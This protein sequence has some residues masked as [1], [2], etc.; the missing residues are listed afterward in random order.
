MKLDN[1]TIR[2]RMI[3]GFALIVALMV[4]LAWYAVASMQEE[5]QDFNKLLE[6]S[7]GATDMVELEAGVRANGRRLFE[8][9]AVEKDKQGQIKDRI[10]A[11]KKTVDDALKELYLHAETEAEKAALKKAEELRDAFVAELKKVID[12]VDAG[13]REKAVQIALSA[14]SPA[15][16]KLN[17]HTKELVEGAEKKLKQRKEQLDAAYK[18][19]LRTIWMVVLAI[20]GFATACAF[21]ITRSITGPIDRAV[22]AAESVA[23][24]DFA[25]SLDTS[26]RDEI[27]SLM[28]A[29]QTMITSIQNFRAEQKKMAEK[30]EQGWIDEKIPADNFAGEFAAMAH[31]INDLVQAHIN[32][33]MS[34]VEHVTA[35]ANCDFSKPM[36]DLP[37]K[38]AMISKAVNEVRSQLQWSADAAV[39]NS[40]IRQAL[41]NC[42]TNVMIANKDGEIVY[43]NAAVHSM[44]SI[45]QNDIRSQL[46]GFDV[47]KVI[48]SSF[49]QFHKNPSHQRNLLGSLR[50]THRAQIKVGPRI[51]SL[52]A[53]PITSAQGERI[54]TVVEWGDRTAEVLAETELADLVTAAAAGDFSQRVDEN[55]KSGFVG[56]MARAMNQLLQVSEEGLND[57]ARVLSALAAG[58]LSQRIHGDYHGTFGALKDDA[59][60]TSERLSEVMYEV[61]QAADALSGAAG[62]ISATAQ[63]LSQAAS[64]QAS[65]VERTS[66][67]VEQMSA[68]VAQNSENAKITDGMASQSSQEAVQGG[69]AVQKTADAMKQIAAKIGIVDDIA[70]Q[71]NLLA[72]NAA[73]EAARAGEHGKG[74][75]V[76]AAEVRKLAERSQVAAKEIGE[77]AASSVTVSD[78]AGNLLQ[79]MIPSIR[80]T[81]DL[82]QEISAASEEQSLGLGQIS[83][84]MSQLNQVTQQ[85][86]SASEELAATAEEMSGQAE[87]LQDLVGFFQIDGSAKRQEERALPPPAASKPKRA[88]AA[89][90]PAALPDE[91]M[92]RRF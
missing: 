68:S 8:L 73:I 72:L 9:L 82:V 3:G 67:S 35:Y 78:Q 10:A 6:I 66:A 56:V 42:S 17:T 55:G 69:E 2:Q 19:S 84:A 40:R 71:T 28:R 13:E 60:L 79:A 70:Y 20:A 51:F 61:R 89:P 46:P 18:S 25:I 41:D 36:Q 27:G 88:S 43:M 23:A 85:N 4:G 37:G 31:S 33:K 34:V 26:A 62:Q 7:D 39:T 75:A 77:L 92:F 81:S 16:D 5:Y 30:H 24:G 87:Q 74:F 50:S 58:D 54:G 76:V 22:D 32:V 45:A 21:F 63:S 12:A 14:A 90:A 11:N 29:L 52:I 38:K 47:S 64:E 44:L 53:N 83:Q 49:D 1:F 80:K 86:A 59:N 15:L 48:G 91:S 57:V 65:G